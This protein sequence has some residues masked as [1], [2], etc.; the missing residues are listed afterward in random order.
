MEFGKS[1]SSIM[2]KENEGGNKGKNIF[3]KGG[4]ISSIKKDK[5]KNREKKSSS[6]FEEF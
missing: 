2:G 5:K 6:K 4:D 1:S 3:D